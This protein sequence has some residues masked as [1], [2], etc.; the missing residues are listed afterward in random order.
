M[1]LNKSIIT[2]RVELQKSKL[3]KS[4]NN[5]FAGFSYYELSDFLPTLN[6]LMLKESVN[7]I[8]TI[9]DG[10][11]RLTLIKDG[12]EQSYEMPF[13]RFETPTNTRINKTTK[14]L[15]VVKSM[16]DIQYLGA[17]NTYYKR[18]L[19]LNAFGITDGEVIDGMNNENLAPKKHGSQQELQK[20]WSLRLKDALIE[21]SIDFKKF[22]KHFKLN[23][24][25]T[26]DELQKVHNDLIGYSDEE[27]VMLKEALLDT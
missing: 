1:G 14:D 26:Q 11:A 7:D 4:G 9:K 27:I 19:Y 8:Y 22:A 21:R 2:I 6:E 18:Y 24:N 23:K 13:E 25:T 12:E 3:K 10:V 15:E 16:Q 20:N 17:L 5:K